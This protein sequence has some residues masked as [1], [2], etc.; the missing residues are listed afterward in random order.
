MTGRTYAAMAWLVAVCW[1]AAGCG[2]RPE[3]APAG[4]EAVDPSG[5]TVT[6]WYQHPGEREAVLAAHIDRF[7]QSNEY[8][9]KVVGER[10][11]THDEV[12]AAMLMRMQSGGLPQLV[13]AYGYQAQ[14]YYRN[15]GVVDLLPYMNSP[16]WGLGPEE[17]GD[18]FQGTLEQDRF[19]GAQIAL[20]PS[21]SMEV[22][23]YNVDWLRELGHDMPPRDWKGFAAVCSQAAARPFSRSRAAG[24]SYGLSVDVDASRIAAMVFSRG[25]DL[26]GAGGSA[27]TLNT[28]QM[29]ASLELLRSLVASGAAVL[30]EDPEAAR[31]DFSA[32]KALFNIRSTSGLPLYRSEVAGGAGFTWDVGPVPYEGHLPTPDVYGASLAVCRSTPEQQLAAWL[33]VRW[34]TQPE[35][36]RTWSEATGYFPVRR[37]AA[38]DVASYFRIPYG[39]MELGKPE[40]SAVGYGAV[41]E[42]IEKTMVQVA[43]GADVD[44]ALVELE[45]E[46]NR[47]LA[48]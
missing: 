30:R 41:R 28:P 5:Q 1:G 11:G 21:R 2:Q 47:T 36:Q 19:Q 40:P 29:R 3:R 22:L 43:R 25:G 12:Y 48:Q 18:F 45:R 39:L 38:R 35:P 31:H 32:G 20:L 44:R 34:F 15:N 26:I 17:R 46:A 27:Y 16:R 4:L 37:S 14:A 23:Y 33:F 24:P 8:G 42:M 13:T 6:F 7:N 9:I 10:I